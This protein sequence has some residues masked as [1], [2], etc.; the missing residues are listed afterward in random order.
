MT[1]QLASVGPLREQSLEKRYAAVM[2]QLRLTLAWYGWQQI[3]H[4]PAFFAEFAKLAQL[5]DDIND[6]HE[7]YT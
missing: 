7:E 3:R 4:T 1:I 5:Y 6:G 2:E